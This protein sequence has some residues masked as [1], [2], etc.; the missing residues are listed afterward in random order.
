MDGAP[1]TAVLCLAMLVVSWVLLDHREEL[2]LVVIRVK[3]LPTMCWMDD[4]YVGCACYAA[5]HDVRRPL[6]DCGSSVVMFVW[7]TKSMV[8]VN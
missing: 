7:Q 4:G 1:G 2:V 8:D 5:V 6:R 3:L